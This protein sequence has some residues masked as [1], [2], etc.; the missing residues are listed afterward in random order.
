MDFKDIIAQEIAA[1]K[2]E[3]ELAKQA[4]GDA[5][6]LKRSE[7]ER[8]RLEEAERERQRLAELKEVCIFNGLDF[9]SDFFRPN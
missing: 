9:L 4:K 6:Y 1:K 5:A 8:Q 7:L 3:L 2:R